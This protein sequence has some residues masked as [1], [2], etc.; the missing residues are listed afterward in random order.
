MNKLFYNYAAMG[1]AVM[2]WVAAVYLTNNRR[3]AYFGDNSEE[4]LVDRASIGQ[5]EQRIN[6]G[7]LCFLL[8]HT[9]DD[10]QTFI[11]KLRDLAQ[12]T[13]DE[14]N[15]IPADDYKTSMVW[16]KVDV[17]PDRRQELSDHAG[18]VSDVF[19]QQSCDVQRIDQIE[20]Q[21]QDIKEYFDN[22]FEKLDRDEQK[23]LILRFGLDG[24]P[25]RSMNEISSYF[26]EYTLFDT[27]RMVR[28]ALLKLF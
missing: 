2:E 14:I 3:I 19:I 5:I 17:T 16:E 20:V 25:C 27:M 26:E 24:G 8:P 4:V 21:Y 28:D 11:E 1:E 9:K 23:M 10:R 6:D 7:C 22:R 13:K 12:K 18:F 15:P